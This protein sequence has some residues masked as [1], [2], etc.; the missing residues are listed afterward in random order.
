[1]TKYFV[2]ASMAMLLFIVIRS[3][4]PSSAEPKWKSF[5]NIN[6]LTMSVDENNITK[7]GNIR[8]TWMI[9]RIANDPRIDSSQIIIDCDRRLISSKRDV[10]F[11]IGGGTV[12]PY[13]TAMFDN[14]PIIPGSHL[15]IVS[16]Y[17]CGKW[18]W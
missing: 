6:G 7:S 4:S 1:M 5:T 2:F 18:V 13:A 3:T 12:S 14:T 16:Q 15:Y 11:T 8:T 10:S 9:T 17:V